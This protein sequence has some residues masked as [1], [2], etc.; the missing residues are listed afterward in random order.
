MRKAVLML[1]LSL[2][3]TLPGA[4]AAPVEAKAPAFTASGAFV[5]LSVPDLEAS[6]R[7]YVEKLGLAVVFRPPEHEGTRVVVLEGGG[8]TVELIDPPRAV[9]LAQAAPAVT[10]TTLVHGIFKAGVVVDDYAATLARL[11]ERG[12]EI[13]LGPFPA[14]D[15]VRA[16][17][18]I[19]DNAGNFLQFFGSAP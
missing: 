7:W 16:N 14:R 2:A 11:R 15:G 18:I 10:H 9:S 17:F 4:P 8:L 12:V 3:A 13:A 5:A 6:E 1:L 19:R